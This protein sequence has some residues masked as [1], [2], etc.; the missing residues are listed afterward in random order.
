MLLH[1]SPENGVGGKNVNVPSLCFG[2]LTQMQDDAARP[3]ETRV[4][5]NV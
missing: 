4:A 5:D 1:G 3:T 2:S